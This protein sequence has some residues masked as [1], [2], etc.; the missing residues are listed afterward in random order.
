MRFVPIV[1]WLPRIAG[2]IP[3]DAV[4]G[5]TIWGLLIPEMIAYA[6][7][8][9]RPVCPLLASLGIYVL[10][11]QPPAGWWPR[12]CVGSPGLLGGDRST[13]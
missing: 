7:L 13:A 1:R 6:S 2:P 4:A 9:C 5:A 11:D 8:A 12:L 10:R 3:I